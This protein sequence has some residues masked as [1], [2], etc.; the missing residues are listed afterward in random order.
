MG[1]KKCAGQ[2]VLNSA[3]LCS[4]LGILCS[5]SIPFCVLSSLILLLARMFF[6]II[7]VVSLKVFLAH[8]SMKLAASRPALE[9]T[10]ASNPTD[11]ICRSIIFH[12][13]IVFIQD[14]KTLVENHV[15]TAITRGLTSEVPEEKELALRR[16]KALK[17][18]MKT[19]LGL[20]W[21]SGQQS[22]AETYR[23]LM[24]ILHTNPSAQPAQLNKAADSWTYEILAKH[25]WKIGMQDNNASV[26]APVT[27]SGSFVIA[28]PLAMQYIRS[29]RGTSP[30]TD[31]F[32]VLEI[33]RMMRRMHIDFVPWKKETRGSRAAQPNL[34][35]ILH[36]GP[37]RSLNP[38]QAVQSAEEVTQEL[39]EKAR[40]EEP[41]VEW[42]I[43]EKLCEMKDLWEKEVLPSDWD[44][45]HASLDSCRKQ[46][47]AAYVWKTYDFVETN[48]DGTFWMHHLALICGIL[49]SRVAP[50]IFFPRNS[51][52][53]Q[54]S[55][56]QQLTKAIR[57]I[58]WTRKTTGSHKG[59]TAARPFVTMVT[60]ALIGF[61]DTR[62]DLFKHLESSGGKL[63][64]SW[65][66]KHGE[67]LIKYCMW[68]LRNT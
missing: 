12:V 47:E 60:T 38:M 67:Y 28:L 8:L 31:T 29:V 65:T 25:F 7:N 46:P 40:D 39:A 58:T 41:G 32:L 9:W 22:N 21:S 49:F 57:A 24:T 16:K 4:V 36:K 18:W 35:M 63:G 1:R 37:N 19:L 45:K 48:Y 44:L 59:M 23:Y 51:A 27:S 13:L 15:R 64:D 61:W 43:P 3:F 62:T 26:E 68:L 56:V 66:S 42:D 53:P 30:D 52:L 33:A 14:C 54:T 6:I 20:A 55:D 34:W 2:C 17:N 50:S 5:A 10:M 11:T